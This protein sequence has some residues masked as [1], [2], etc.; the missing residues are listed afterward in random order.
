[1]FWGFFQI[2]LPKAEPGGDHSPTKFSIS[3]QQQQTTTTKNISKYWEK[4]LTN[5]LAD[6][7]I[8]VPSPFLTIMQFLEKN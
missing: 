6:P 3:E 4:K 8:P 1:M 5:A 2:T 7:G